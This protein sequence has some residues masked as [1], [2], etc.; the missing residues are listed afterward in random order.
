M[1]HPIA[2]TVL[3]IH[4]AG[5]FVTRMF[6][7]TK[8]LLVRKQLACLKELPTSTSIYS[9]IYKQWHLLMQ[10]GCVPPT[11]RTGR[12]KTTKIDLVQQRLSEMLF[13]LLRLTRMYG[14]LTRLQIGRL[15]NRGSI[16]SRD[17]YQTA[18]GTHP[19][20][21]ETVLESLSW[22]AKRL[23]CKADQSPASR[24]R[25]ATVLASPRVFMRRGQLYLLP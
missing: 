25:E 1:Q 11:K 19:T 5:L 15:S 4:L 20:F 3:Y 7:D 12:R 17:N 22:W 16:T 6:C 23:G 24:M 10:C 13:G 9:Y 21:Y 18:C 8:D 2:I 14:M